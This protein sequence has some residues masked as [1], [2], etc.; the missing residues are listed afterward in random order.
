MRDTLMF[1]LQQL[2]EVEHE[3]GYERGSLVGEQFPGDANSAE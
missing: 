3:F 1:C 2:A